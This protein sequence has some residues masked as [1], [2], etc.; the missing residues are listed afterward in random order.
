MKYIQSF[1]LLLFLVLV[2]GCIKEDRSDCG[3]TILRFSY[4][5]DGTTEIFRNKM[6]SVDLYVFDSNNEC[7]HSLPLEQNE[8]ASQS[9]SLFLKPGTYRA[10]CIGNAMEETVTVGLSCQNF[11]EMRCTHPHCLDGGVIATNDSLYHGALTFTV[12][13]SRAVDETIQ[14]HAAHYDVCVEV[15]GYT[16]QEGDPE[17]PLALQWTGMSEW[18]NFNNEVTSD[19]L[20]DY[21]PQGQKMKEGYIFHFDM[22]R[23]TK[24][25]GI[26]LKDAWNQ[27]LYQMNLCDFIAQHPEVDLMKEELLIPILIEFKSVGVQVSIPDWAVEQIKPEF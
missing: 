15:K 18:V 14:F 6:K 24:Q 1:I 11:H 4:V 3:R 10:V 8:L 19:E 26:Q 17:I 13:D 27:M 21:F 2:T 9:K 22:L 7:V 5:G 23:Q 20:T 12:P 25:V 16:P